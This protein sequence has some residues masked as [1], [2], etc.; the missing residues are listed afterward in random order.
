M[1]VT[2]VC[3]DFDVTKW[4]AKAS[5]VMRYY[6]QAAKMYPAQSSSTSNGCGASCIG[7]GV[8]ESPGRMRITSGQFSTIVSCSRQSVMNQLQMQRKAKGK[9]K[10]RV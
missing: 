9:R 3:C 6:P 10:C 2:A 7:L 4:T 5:N 1:C 8:G